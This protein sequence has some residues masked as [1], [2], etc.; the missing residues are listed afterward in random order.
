MNAGKVCCERT[1]VVACFFEGWMKDVTANGWHKIVASAGEVA[2]AALVIDAQTNAGTIMRCAVIGHD[3]EFGPTQ[4][5]AETREHIF[6]RI[7]FPDELLIVGY[8][9]ESASTA[10]FVGGAC[11]RIFCGVFKNV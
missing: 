4:V 7:G 9:L 2:G 10:Q 1:C 3:G 5:S 6:E 11:G 8:A